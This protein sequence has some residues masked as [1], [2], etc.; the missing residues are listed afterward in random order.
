VDAEF[1]LKVSEFEI[2]KP[3]YLGVGVRDE[4]RV[5]VAFNALPMSTTASTR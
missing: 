4:I 5:K 3:T 2:P 1:P